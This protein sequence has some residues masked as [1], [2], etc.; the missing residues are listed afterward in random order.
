M[1]SYIMGNS[2]CPGCLCSDETIQHLLHCPHPFMKAKRDEIVAALRKKGLRAH[3][4][5]TFLDILADLI[6]GTVTPDPPVNPTHTLHRGFI[7][8]SKIGFDLFLRGFIAKQWTLD[9]RELGLSRPSNAISWILR[10]IWFD[11]TDALWRTQ[12]DILH[13]NQNE[14][15]LLEESRLQDQLL[16][17]LDNKDCIAHSDRYLLNYSPTDIPSLPLRTTKELFRLLTKA[18]TSHTRDLLVLAKGQSRITDYF[19]VMCGVV[20]VLAYDENRQLKLKSCLNLTPRQGPHS[21]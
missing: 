11:C 1:L 8:Q 10:F 12:N 3:L 19:T 18:Q 16:W 4:P 7:A 21:S 6:S 14:H 17:F 2:Q 20:H 9:L 13:H 5:M 15:T